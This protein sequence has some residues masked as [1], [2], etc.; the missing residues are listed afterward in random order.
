M[1]TTRSSRRRFAASPPPPARARLGARR[2]GSG[3]PDA[4]SRRYAT[5]EHVFDSLASPVVDEVLMGFNCT[6]FAYG[7]TGSGKTHTLM[8][9]PRDP[10]IIVQSAH[11]VFH[12]L[13]GASGEALVR[14]AGEGP[15]RPN[16]NIQPKQK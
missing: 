2:R 16:L 7:Q 11:D 13:A 6:I 5:Q 12:M 10:G 1:R 8:G 15:F 14:T 3:A 9:N 4:R